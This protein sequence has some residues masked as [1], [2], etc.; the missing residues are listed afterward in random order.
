M[1]KNSDHTD[2]YIKGNTHPNFE[3]NRLIEEELINVIIQKLEMLIFSNKGDLYG[4][5]ILGSDLEYYLWSTSVP[6]YE[7][8]KKMNNQISLYI[9]ELITIGYSLSVDIYEGT[10]KDI[11]YLRFGINNYNINF[12]MD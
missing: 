9:P 3:K 12:I 4:D 8:K 6:S 5:P 1:A 10:L 7:I 2:F 11:M